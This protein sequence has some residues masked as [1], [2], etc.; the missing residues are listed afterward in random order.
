MN[1]DQ[2]LILIDALLMLN[3]SISMHID[4]PNNESVD[5]DI[6]NIAVSISKD[7]CTLKK[8]LENK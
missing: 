4:N 5:N 6:M 1:D 3:K 7:L 2:V 8:Q